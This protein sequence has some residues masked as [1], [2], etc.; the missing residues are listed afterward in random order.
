MG[1][2][3][4]VHPATDQPPAGP[5]SAR[6]RPAESL[7]ALAGPALRAPF[8]GRARRDLL[9]C[10]IEVPLGL[11]VFV[12]PL[13]LSGLLIAVSLL[14][15]G[16][17]PSGSA[18]Q[19]HPAA[20]LPVLLGGFLI[21]LMLVILLPRAARRL[22]AAHRRLAA[23]VL[24]EPVAAPS[25]VRPA[26]G[27]GR[28]DATLRDGPGWRAAAYLLVKLPVW[29]IEIY[30]AF[31][32][33]AGLA[34]LSYPFWWPLF[35]NH[36]P[37]VHL[38]PVPVFTP[39]GSFHVATFAGTFAAFAAGVAM[40]L[41]APWVAR[42]GAAAD[43]W[44]M[45]GMLG[46][47][48]LARRVADLEQ[49]RALAVEDS[50]ALLRRLERDL[51]DG[52]QIRLATLAMNLGLAREKLSA[53]A[54]PE[55]RELVDSAHQGAKDALVELR[56]LARG[57]HPPAL[58]HGLADALATLA[59]SSPIPV[60]LTTALPRRPAPAIETIAYFCAAEL[61]ANAAKHSHANQVT[62]DVTEPG[63]AL[64]LRVSDDGAGGADPARGSGLSGL[65]QRS[66]T[67]DGRVEIVS[68]PGGPTQVTVTLPM[69]A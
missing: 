24:R 63:P 64:V 9:F 47:G 12:F 41:A 1:I 68:P 54:D 69:H 26:Q 21:L 10:L 56:T 34:G 43:V 14:A 23:G 20:V 33:V 6:P 62:V 53:D 18:S 57:L 32:A 2:T 29:V 67:V 25:P 66:R 38:Q 60:T 13:V 7:A 36:G 61:L 8:A 31:L 42:A 48:R 52:A 55:V 35:R 27:I 39:F 50:A 45:R 22:G 19:A 4:P 30:A 16:S 46:P 65:A 44:L 49:S 5:H 59:A 15:R 17:G 51:H 11:G 40:V 3:G 37:G 28:L 58:D